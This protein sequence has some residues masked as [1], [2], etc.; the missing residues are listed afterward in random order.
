[1]TTLKAQ[2]DSLQERFHQMSDE[3]LSVWI[4]V[5]ESKLP[6][7]R[8]TEEML[9]VLN[10]IHAA[11]SVQRYRE[12][13]WEWWFKVTVA[14]SLWVAHKL[15]TKFARA[16]A[17]TALWYLIVAKN[18]H[19]LLVLPNSVVLTGLGIGARKKMRKNKLDNDG[20]AVILFLVVC[21]T[22]IFLERLA[23][24]PTTHESFARMDFQSAF[25][26]VR[27]HTAHH[28]ATTAHTRM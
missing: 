19:E 25:R 23:W 5:A 9:S 27:V 7:Y 14:T 2:Y 15:T 20:L 28:E 21:V 1:M 13:N 17:N 18:L 24:K 26:P 11:K 3:M 22:V 8:R 12:N 10:G 16:V 6:H 4:E